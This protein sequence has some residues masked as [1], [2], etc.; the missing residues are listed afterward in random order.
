MNNKNTLQTVFIFG[1]FALLFVLILRMLMPFFS[2][3]LWTVLLYILIKPLYQKCFNKLNKTKK[4]FRLKNHL[5]AAIF[6]I[7]TLVIIVG[8]MAAISILL[9]EQG[10]ELLSKAEKFLVEN[11][12]FLDSEF[13][14]EKIQELSVKTKINFAEINF[15]SFEEEILTFI[16]TY[17]SRLL[18][19]G[20]SF[21]GKTGSFVISLV[22][23]VFA[24]YF[25]FLDGSYLVRLFKIAIPINASHMNVLTKKFSDITKN[26]FS[27]YILVAL[28]Q[29][30]AAF[31]IFLCFGV[32]GS[33]L[34]AV[35][36]MFATF[37]PLFGAAIV[38]LP[39]G[40]VL[41][42]SDSLFKGLLFLIISG[43][44]ISFLD[45]FLRPFFLKDRINLHPLVIFFSILGGI[46][47]FGLNGLILGPLVIILF[48]TV[49]N[50]IIASKDKIEQIEE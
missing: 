45:N 41:C 9:I 31:V 10:I 7:G 38:W 24:L 25:C 17:S 8:A 1:L 40:I 36:L 32:Q 19:I 42:I 50:L 21:V 14:A 2:V 27:G 46:Q 43:V 11:P 15:D 12:N 20:K 22:F 30:L 37:I 39:I 49:L 6:A 4:F 34:L 26:L 23:V 29:G 28:Y 47:L 13:L 5:L 44:C 33:L 16:R 18:S 48:F 3:I 35:V